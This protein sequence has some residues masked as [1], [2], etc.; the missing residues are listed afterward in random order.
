MKNVK[1][2]TTQ[3]LIQMHQAGYRRCFQQRKYLWNKL[4]QAQE[5]WFRKDQY[6]MKVT[7]VLLVPKHQTGCFLV[8]PGE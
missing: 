2:N 4:I 6:V 7:L 3:Q 1:R 8:R 5:F